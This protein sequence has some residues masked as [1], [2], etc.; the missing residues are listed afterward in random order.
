M[1]IKIP[2]L[3]EEYSIIYTRVDVTPEMIDCTF[4]IPDEDG[5]EFE[6]EITEALE[7]LNVTA[8]ADKLSKVPATHFCDF[9]KSTQIYFT[10]YNFRLVPLSGVT[11][12][13]NIQATPSYN[14]TNTGLSALGFQS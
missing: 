6:R 11:I 3:P 1:V 12:D 4:L 8:T 7:G 5:S 9:W 10:N 13:E 2:A 14:C